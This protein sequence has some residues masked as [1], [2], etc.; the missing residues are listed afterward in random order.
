MPPKRKA[1]S[2]GDALD[3]A[4]ICLAGT[5]SRPRIEIEEAIKRQGGRVVASVTLGCTH[6]VCTPSEFEKLSSK[7][8][9]T[10]CLIISTHAVSSW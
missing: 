6:L 7:V 8:G 1:V 5:L 4:T 2:V 10:Q 3:G 9:R